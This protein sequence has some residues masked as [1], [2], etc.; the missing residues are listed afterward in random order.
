MAPRPP[1]D[2][3]TAPIAH[4][5]GAGGE[6][7]REQRESL[8]AQIK[9][10][11][12]NGRSSVRMNRNKIVRKLLG[13]PVPAATSGR[14]ETAAIDSP[15]LRP[16]A[17]QNT[18]YQAGVPIIC[19]DK[20]PDG[21]RAVFAGSK[22]FKIV[23]VDGSTISEE[24]DLR[25]NIVSHATSHNSL[26]SIGEQLNIKTVKWSHGALDHNILAASGNGRIT[27]YDINQT[28]QG[29]EVARIEE[30]R[31]VHKLAINPFKS[32]WVLAASS[33]RTVRSFDLRV[34]SGGNHGPAF[35]LWNTYN[36]NAETVRDV[37]WS[38]TDGM[39]FACCTDN[40]IV[41]K[42]DIRKPGAPVLRIVAHQKLCSSID[43][44]PDGDHL[45]SGGSD[46]HCH[47]WDFSPKA[48]GNQK[49]AY[50]FTTAAPVSHVSWRPACWSA[51]AQG[52]RA[53]QVTVA[54]E[55]IL[56]KVSVP[57][58][59]IFDLA[60]PS[61]PFKEVGGWEKPPS[62]LL[63][64]TRDLLWS[65][66]KDGN[67]SQTDVAFT[68]KGIDRRSLSTFSFSP[69]GDVLMM[70][71]ERPV[72][73]RRSRPSI[74]STEVSPSFQ[75]SSSIPMLS[76]S[77]S[78]S[79][80]DVVGS[81][82][83]PRQK[84]S[85]RRRSS[86]RSVYLM[87]TT[88]PNSTGMADNKVMSLDDAVKVTGLYKTQQIMAVGH[89]PS[90][91]IRNEYRHFSNRYML[92]MN[93]Y[94]SPGFVEILPDARVVAITEHFAKTAEGASK[95]RLAQTWRALGYTV[96]ILLTRR[97]EHN[98]KNRLTM[99]DSPMKEEN[100]TEATKELLPP[101]DLSEETPRKPAGPTRSRTP[102][103]SPSHRL[104]K[105]IMAEEMESTSNVATPL[106]RPVPDSIAARTREAMHTPISVEDDILNLPEASQTT[107][108][109]DPIP[110]PGAVQ[111]DEKKSA[112][113]EGYDFYGIDS[114]SPIA[115]F[116]VPQ[117]KQP[118][119]F[120]YS[121]HHNSSQRIQPQRHDSGESF[122]MFSTSGDS[123]N[124]KFLSSST[125]SESGRLLRD[126]VSSWENS[127]GSSHANNHRPSI[128]SEAP[129]QSSG[130][131]GKSYGTT[132]AHT[133]SGAQNGMPFDPAV[134]PIFHIQE[135]S[136]KSTAEIVTNHAPREEE[137][138]LSP[139]SAE[140]PSE[141]LSPELVESDFIPRDDDPDFTP[142]P[143]KAASLI[144]RAI[145]FECLTGSLHAAA[146]VLLF[147]PL[148]P[149][150]SIDDIQSNAI[151]R[152]YQQRLMSMKLFTESAL[153]RNLCIPD[154][155]NV[156]TWAQEK[157]S[158]AFYCTNC[159]KPLD[160]DPLLPNSQ[161]WCPRCRG[162]IDG[163]AVCRHHELPLDNQYEKENGIENEEDNAL[164]W[165]C[166]G[167]A[168]GGHTACMQAWHAGS[169]SHEGDIHSSGS[170]PLE[171]CVHPCLPGKWRE[172]L[173][174]E[175]EL[176]KSRKLESL[177]RENTRAAA[178]VG[179][180]SVGIGRGQGLR[181][182]AKSVIRDNR[183]VN[184]SKAVE[185][186]RVAL[187]VG[188]PSLE[189]KKSVKLVAPGEEGK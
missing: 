163:C 86:Q 53:A 97:A 87:S 5:T 82:L 95:Y 19:L 14:N 133:T 7:L 59:H 107:T 17:S 103:T 179:P 162:E 37:K 65:V 152:Q 47:V 13:Q 151:L 27:L 30:T 11:A 178:G 140:R 175:E 12:L 72:P 105:S 118:L 124:A 92:R 181:G 120:D 132:S 146:M 66:D 141:D 171:G 177:V 115:D 3:A 93:K 64:S 130:S 18:T 164:W 159:E 157:V 126:R 166:P 94:K 24:L 117:R 145:D 85:H 100:G 182:A 153:L 111:S 101:Q 112:S 9:D 15:Q 41:Q 98:R 49:A 31:E 170:C 129:T 127:L 187:G 35:H 142:L 58:V 143:M 45:V 6:V 2:S 121:S 63:W 161:W 62:G 137:L 122:Q 26:T 75:H 99:R 28:G 39:M 108:K 128:S 180:G 36:C 149:S 67:F 136:M 77:R 90:T 109:I 40:G 79:E 23:K 168:H 52:K 78:D 8:H 155:P 184:Q 176:A 110:V 55:D 16:S 125:G 96:N 73:R 91:A 61:L 21:Q 69:N 10:A 42:W 173:K 32:D 138:P 148:L 54:Y 81:F 165:Y 139:R 56:S 150:W 144:Q 70:L 113:I 172:H 123:H 76:I 186:V 156:F 134:P 33:N 116:H 185:G 34:R 160:N 44:H 167:C 22:V 188:G 38:P 20:S 50:S 25:S 174:E 169:E 51:T 106:V 135:P 154:Y 147:R 4:G 43:W 102:R 57:D 71:E 83:G 158:V 119:R 74:T 1:W 114:I 189:R 68:P 89:A 84:K 80:E 131:F 46:G 48:K 88:P 183:E 29:L 60:R 104:A